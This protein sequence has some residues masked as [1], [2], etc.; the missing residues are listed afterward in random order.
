LEV[1]YRV[2]NGGIEMCINLGDIFQIIATVLALIGLFFVWW[3]IRKQT[4]QLHSDRLLSL[5]KDLDTTES[6][7]DRKFIYNEFPKIAKLTDDQEKRVRRVLAA[8]DRMSYQVIRKFADRKSAY[9]LYGRVL[10]HV[11]INTWQ[12]LNQDRKIRNDPKGWEYCSNAERLAREFAVQNLREYKKW[13]D[14]YKALPFP[15]LLEISLKARR[16]K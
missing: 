4:E 8:S 3:Q 2:G 14:S 9:E 1:T 16:Q 7:E 11:M 5:Y 13:K 12:W 10:R 15:E 6:Q